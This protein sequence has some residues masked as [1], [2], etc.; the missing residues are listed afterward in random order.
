MRL[1]EVLLEDQSQKTAK[2]TAEW[3]H[4][5]CGK[6]VEFLGLMALYD[7]TKKAFI[8]GIR[9]VSPLDVL[10]IILIRKKAGAVIIR[11]RQT[12]KADCLR[13]GCP[14][15]IEDARRLVERF[16]THYN[17]LPALGHRLRHSS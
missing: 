13:P 1:S 7:Q 3:S 11:W 8:R 2:H 10:D 14:L 9:L 16:V 17:T 5:A 6:W 15:S 4:R 12:L